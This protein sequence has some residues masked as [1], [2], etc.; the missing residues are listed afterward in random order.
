MIL[1]LENDTL[2][3]MEGD[4][5]TSMNKFEKD[6]AEEARVAKLV[7]LELDKKEKETAKA[8]KIVNWE[9]LKI[10]FPLL[11]KIEGKVTVA[12]KILSE[13][14]NFPLIQ[15]ITGHVEVDFPETQKIEGHVNATVDFPKKQEVHGTVKAEVNF[16]EEQ[17]VTGKVFAD[18]DLTKIQTLFEKVIGR[19]PVAKDGP[20]SSESNNPSKYIPVRLTTGRQFYDVMT[21]ASHQNGQLIAAINNLNANNAG[22]W[23]PVA[24][25]SLTNSLQQLP[26]NARTFGGYFLDNPNASKIYIQV[27]IDKP[28]AILG[29]TAPDAIYGVPASGDANL[30]LSKGLRVTSSIMVAATTTANGS[31]APGSACPVT[32]YYR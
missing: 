1:G 9:D 18:L 28:N 2:N 6:S 31:T 23:T 24:Y 13:V 25:A 16:P 30:E 17:K 15:K 8:S 14:S 27:F 29:S 19:I 21:Q 26:P 32:F 20:I 3:K 12:N 7:K 11:Q 4:T 22:N 5:K 10:I